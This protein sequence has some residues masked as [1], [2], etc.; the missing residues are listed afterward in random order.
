MPRRGRY[1][2]VTHNKLL[3]HLGPVARIMVSANHL[4]RSIEFCMFLCRETRA[5][6]FGT[7]SSLCL[8]QDQEEPEGEVEGDNPNSG[9]EESSPTAQPAGPHQDSRDRSSPITEQIPPLDASDTVVYN[10]AEPGET[11]KL[12]N[13]ESD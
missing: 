4:F 7:D 8:L 3:V 10:D 11:T 13:E 2:V 12:L 6:Y 5:W 9:D 1:F